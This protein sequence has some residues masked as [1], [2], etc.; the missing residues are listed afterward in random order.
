[1]M[2]IFYVEKVKRVQGCGWECSSKIN[3]NQ[4]LY[5]LGMWSIR[6]D[7]D[8]CSVTCDDIQIYYF[9]LIDKAIVS[10]LFFFFHLLY[11]KER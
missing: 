5:I 4:M 1:M 11:T 6:F 3:V 7:S 2:R 10:I 8:K 9:L